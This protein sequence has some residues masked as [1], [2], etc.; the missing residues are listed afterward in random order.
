MPAYE[1][2]TPTKREVMVGLAQHLGFDKPAPQKDKVDEEDDWRRIHRMTLRHREGHGRES[3]IAE[4]DYKDIYGKGIS[5]DTILRGVELAACRDAAYQFGGEC[6][7]VLAFHGK[8]HPNRSRFMFKI[9]GGQE[10]QSLAVSGPLGKSGEASIAERLM[11]DILKYVQSKEEI[12]SRDRAQLWDAIMSHHKQ[13]SDVVTSYTDREMHIRE[14]ELNA[15][16]HAYERLKKRQEDDDAKQMKREGWEMVKEHGPKLLPYIA[17][18]VRGRTEGGIGN[19]VAPGFEDW[20]SQQQEAPEQR[21]RGAGSGSSPQPEAGR[22]GN[23]NGSGGRPSASPS[24]EDSASE[25]PGPEDSEEPALIEKLKFRVAFD[26]SRFVMLIRGRGQFEAVRS[27]FNDEQRGAFDRVVESCEA[28]DLE[29]D[30]GI[31]RTAQAVLVFGM[32]IML[33]DK[34]QGDVM[35]ALDNMSKLALMELTNLLKIYHEHL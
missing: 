27:A 28:K 2:S 15:D 14:I 18:M 17:K 1:F 24:K 16:D 33:D 26:T 29:E 25:S 12:L 20:F 34:A 30:A 32:S 7:Y 31:E 3:D 9:F 23:G 21:R 5:L 35:S 11:P 22:N 8:D 4:W 6:V 13:L 10:V 19:G